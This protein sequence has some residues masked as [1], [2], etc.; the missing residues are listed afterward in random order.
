MGWFR[1]SLVEL[2]DPC[3]QFQVVERPCA[4]I[5]LTRGD[6]FES[7]PQVM[8]NPRRFV[9]FGAMHTRVFRSRLASD[10]HGAR[11]RSRRAM[12][13]NGAA[14]K[15][16][17]EQDARKAELRRKQALERRA[18]AT[19][20]A[21]RRERDDA[22]KRE[23]LEQ[24]QRDAEAR[25]ARERVL[26]NNEGVAWDAALVGVRSD[27]AVLK[28]IRA[29]A[30]DKIVLPPSAWRALERAGALADGSA[31]RGGHVFFEVSTPAGARTHA[32]VLGFDGEEGNAGLPLP[33]LRQ[34]GLV[35]PEGEARAVGR[36]DAP[37][38]APEDGSRSLAAKDRENDGQNAADGMDAPGPPPRRPFVPGV[39]VAPLAA[40]VR[41][42]YRRL[43][44]G[45][46]AKLQ[47][48]SQD[49]QGEL[50]AEASVDL[51][52]LL[53]RAMTRR[54]TLTVGD[55]IV[56]RR[57]EGE[58]GSEPG[59]SK[60]KTYSLRVVEVQPDDALGAVSLME[61]DVEVD[62]APSVDYEE[63]MRALAEAERRRL[64]AAAR[65]RG[66]RRRDARTR[67]RERR[68]RRGRSR[69]A[70][71]SRRRSAIGAV[72]RGAPAVASAGA[73]RRRFRRDAAV[74]L[75]APRRGAGGAAIFPH[76]SRRGGVQLRQGAERGGERGGAVQARD[77]VPEAGGRG[78]GGR[79]RRG[80]GH[81][82]RSRGDVVRREDR[83]RG[84]A[85]MRRGGVYYRRRASTFSRYYT[86]SEPIQ[87]ER[88]FERSFFL[89]WVQRRNENARATRR[90]FARSHSPRLDYCWYRS[91]PPPSPLAR[92]SRLRRA[93]IPPPW[94]TRRR[95]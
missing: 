24:R 15:L 19:A 47:P 31:S 53:E 13:L 4:V 44:K 57:E 1:S 9:P 8:M 12:F 66:R 55:E 49:F 45:T 87:V 26:A 30:D 82:G 7:I 39:G 65:R 80:G 78:G 21:R 36:R 33:V 88:S 10:L 52:G 58:E 22:E 61:T 92:L 46:Y 59:V 81:G 11:P 54:C 35:P 25:V 86:R 76:G 77:A 32:G 90:R 94:G 51:R 37:E 84:D 3:G 68:R 17:R 64:E 48:R 74:S 62:I 41:V 75:R 93:S 34:L 72:P 16:K 89:V 63:A 69:R 95:A 60:P 79:D 56:V 6:H 71:R 70:R 29:R 67:R 85:A 38:D 20:E 5:N 73:G 18:A 43:P 40:D 42:S 23:R 91:P 2:D 83:R 50:A 28:G 27:A 14:E